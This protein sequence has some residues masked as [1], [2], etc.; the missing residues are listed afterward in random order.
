MRTGSKTESDERNRTDAIRRTTEC[1]EYSPDG[2]VA[3][4]TRPQYTAVEKD[5]GVVGMGFVSDSW[6]NTT[7]SWSAQNKIRTMIL[8]ILGFLGAAL[9][10]FS[11]YHMSMWSHNKLFDQKQP[12]PL[13]ILVLTF[14]IGTGLV[15]Y[16]T[17]TKEQL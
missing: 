3:N 4:H 11:V 1:S 17:I 12:Y 14:C 15:I 5:A 7:F 8:G 9:N 6:N 16:S 2:L 13:W 10:V